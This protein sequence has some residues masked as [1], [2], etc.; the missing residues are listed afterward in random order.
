MCNQKIKTGTRFALLAAVAALTGILST[1]PALAVDEATLQAAQQEGSV[2]FY[3]SSPSELLDQ[4]AQAFSAKYPG[5]KAEYYRAGSSQVYE[6]LIAE[7]DA[8]R[9]NGDLIHVSDVATITELKDAG[10][11]APY[12]SPEYAAYDPQYVDPD[13]NWF[14]ARGH[15][16]N[17]AYNPARVAEGEAPQTLRDLAKPVF[18]GKVG[19]MDVRLA[20]GAYSWQYTVWKLYGPEFFAE[21]AANDPK[22]FPGH[23]PINDRIISGELSTGVSLNYMTDEA[24]LEKGAP[25]KALF[26]ADGAPMIW[27]PVG[28]VDKAPHP[29]AAKVF[30]DFLA[31]AEGQEIYNSQYSYSMR[32]DVP[33]KEGMVPLSEIKI[34]E[35]PI[36]DMIARQREVQ[37]AVR[38]A[39]GY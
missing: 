25:I 10:R 36:D 18:K 33:T 2:V 34:L 9:V 16:L 19:I 5:I 12:D 31:S 24:I 14:V 17:I 7:Q 22:L 4:L 32:P 11:L 30:I 38:K 39:W 3:S 1:R 37:D 20:G 15:F 26:P 21:M 27:S 35:T 28:I 23:G 8:N 29:N 6:R 13:K